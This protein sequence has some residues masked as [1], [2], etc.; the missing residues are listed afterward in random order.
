[1]ETKTYM[2][3]QQYTLICE[4]QTQ[5]AFTHKTV[6]HVVFFFQVIADYKIYKNYHI[7]LLIKWPGIDRS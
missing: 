1:M 5:L 7:L 3:M 4:I 2:H 6:N